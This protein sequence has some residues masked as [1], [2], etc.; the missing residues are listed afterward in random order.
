M[1]EIRHPESPILY[2]D[3]EHIIQRMKEEINPPEEIGETVTMIQARLI[4]GRS[5][6]TITKHCQSVGKSV[7]GTKLYRLID[8][9]KIAK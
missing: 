9:E 3:I 2:K 7:N 1:S 4:C 8:V 5:T 6:N